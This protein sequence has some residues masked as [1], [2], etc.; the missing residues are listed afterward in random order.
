MANET[1]VYMYVSLCAFHLIIFLYVSW[2][3]FWCYLSH[4]IPHLVFVCF[5]WLPF[6][7][8]FAIH[9]H[10]HI[11]IFVRM[12]LAP[13]HRAFCSWTFGVYLSYVWAMLFFTWNIIH[14]PG[15]QMLML[16]IQK[17]SFWDWY[18]CIGVG[19]VL[20]E[21]S[22]TEVKCWTPI[23]KK[24]KL[25]TTTITINNSNITATSTVIRTERPQ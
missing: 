15:V 22:A 1:C 11:H 7:L 24:Q 21:R 18:T 17:P 20:S 12:R 19:K 2:H 8:H 3:L 10:S 23:T 16:C 4:F 6:F 13:V 14:L 9:T 25:T 5:V